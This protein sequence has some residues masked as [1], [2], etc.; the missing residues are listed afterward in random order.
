MSGYNMGKQS[1]HLK[2][3]SYLKKN[4]IPSFSGCDTTMYDNNRKIYD[5]HK[6]GLKYVYEPPRMCMVWLLKL[7]NKIG[8]RVQR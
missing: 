5:H 1:G 4:Q 6:K 7:K 2:N 8:N 3:R